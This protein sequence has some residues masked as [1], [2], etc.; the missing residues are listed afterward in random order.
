MSIFGLH[1]DS[2]FG[3]FLCHLGLFIMDQMELMLF[4]LTALARSFEA[5]HLSDPSA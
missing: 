1:S 2:K 4:F 5:V 3:T